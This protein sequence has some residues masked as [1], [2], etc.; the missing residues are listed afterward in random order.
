[1]KSH[2]HKNKNLVIAVFTVAVLVM[3]TTHAVFA[4]TPKANVKPLFSSKYTPFA[5]TDCSGVT[6]S[7][8]FQPSLNTP[9][10]TTAIYAWSWP[11]SVK[12]GFLC[13]NDSFYATSIQINDVTRSWTTDGSSYLYNQD[14]SG[15]TFTLYVGGVVKTVQYGD[16]LKGISWG[17]YGFNPLLNTCDVTKT[18]TTASWQAT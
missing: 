17:C 9:P 5:W 15:Q 16:T 7:G 1:M 11:S 14:T 12:G 3:A 6:R 18:F 10:Q 2:Q 13:V 8:W 4:D